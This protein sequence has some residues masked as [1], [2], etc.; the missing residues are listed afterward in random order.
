[1][2]ASATRH[3]RHAC[4]RK[5]AELPF[6]HCGAWQPTLQRSRARVLHPLAPSRTRMDSSF[7]WGQHRVAVSTHAV[8]RPLLA[9]V[10]EI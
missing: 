7:V 3:E 9:L 8:V 1:M 6:T 2:L 4:M 10:G 5:E